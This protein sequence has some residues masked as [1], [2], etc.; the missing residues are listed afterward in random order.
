MSKILGLIIVSGKNLL[1]KSK[2][3]KEKKIISK[4]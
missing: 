1:F 2:L 4:D 3:V